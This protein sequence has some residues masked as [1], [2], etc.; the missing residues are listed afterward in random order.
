MRDVGPLYIRMLKRILLNNKTKNIIY[1][2][3]QIISL[4]TNCEKTIENLKFFLP[5]CLFA[6][7]LK[8]IILVIGVVV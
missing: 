4:R 8:L 7:V 6:V 3:S 5:F 2:I 1:F